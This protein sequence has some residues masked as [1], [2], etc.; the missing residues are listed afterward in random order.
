MAMRRHRPLLQHNHDGDH[1]AFVP[2]MSSL[3]FQQQH[4]HRVCTRSAHAMS[5]PLHY[6]TAAA[7]M[8]LPQRVP[9]L[10]RRSTRSVDWHRL[11]HARCPCQMQPQFQSQRHQTAAEAAVVGAT[12]VT[13]T[14]TLTTTST[15]T[16]SSVSTT[17][18]PP[19][20][21]GIAMK[22]GFSI[23]SPA[24]LNT[25]ASASA[26][27]K[28]PSRRK[29]GRKTAFDIQKDRK[30]RGRSVQSRQTLVARY[31]GVVVAQSEQYEVCPCLSGDG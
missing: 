31:N 4:C 2:S 5:A 20:V 6:S 12:T 30:S 21:E 23:S 26:A 19:T 9:H 17:W 28:Y 24:D 18:Y 1:L 15:S 7:H 25:H 8:S 27:G 13:K 11:G 22:P 3:P 29:R 16:V 14:T 10:A